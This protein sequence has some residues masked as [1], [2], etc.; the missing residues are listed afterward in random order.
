MITGGEPL[1]HSSALP[2]LIRALRSRAPALL[3]ELETNGTIAPDADL[4]GLVDL[5][6]V[7]PKL[8]HAGN[9]AGAALRPRA[10]AALAGTEK[11][12]FKFVARDTGDVRTV[13]RLAHDYGI[14]PA[15]VYI[16]PKGT[17]SGELIRTGAALIDAVI[18]AGFNYSDRMHIHLFGDTRGT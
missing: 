3:I 5:L 13:R 6:M 11:A 9:R 15:R 14:A 2:A 1:V 8:D 7:S 4:L 10:L 12:Q 16:M 18:D 17:T